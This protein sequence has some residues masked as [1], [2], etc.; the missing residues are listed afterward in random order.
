GL[1]AAQWAFVVGDAVDEFHD[2]GDLDD[3]PEELFDGLEVVNLAKDGVADGL[4]GFELIL[5][6]LDVTLFFLD[7]ADDVLEGVDLPAALV[8][9]GVDATGGALSDLGD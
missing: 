8:G 3:R 9:D 7:L 2:Q 4:A 1:Y 5:N 6:L